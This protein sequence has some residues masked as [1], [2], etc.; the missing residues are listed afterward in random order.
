MAVRMDKPWQ[1]LTAEAAAALLANM[2]VYQ[3]ADEGGTVLAIRYAGGKTLFGLRGEL[4]REAEERGAG[5]QFRVEVNQQYQTRW[6]ELL[7]VHVADH[8]ELPPE[9]QDE[10]LSTSGLGRLSPL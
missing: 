1:P 6:R 7:M 8:G 2:G 3:I 9:N 10:E 5:Y 4:G